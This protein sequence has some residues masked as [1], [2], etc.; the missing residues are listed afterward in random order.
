MIEAFPIILFSLSLSL[1][2]FV[3]MCACMC[4]H[5]C[6][7]V[8]IYKSEVK[9]GSYLP[10]TIYYFIFIIYTRFLIGLELTKQDRLPDG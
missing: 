9:L 4:T 10:G 5:V 6:G 8:C 2:V 7:D 1:C 3:Y